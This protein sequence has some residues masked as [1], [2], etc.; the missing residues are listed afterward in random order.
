MDT[1]NFPRDVLDRFERRLPRAVT[2][3]D[4]RDDPLRR[5]FEY[6]FATA[7][8]AVVVGGTESDLH[9]RGNPLPIQIKR[10]AL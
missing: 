8:P 7:H 10:K 6:P 3:L 9:A 4:D 2:F 1:P 5:S